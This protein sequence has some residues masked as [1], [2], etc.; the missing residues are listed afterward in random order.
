MIGKEKEEPYGNL[1]IAYQSL[2]DYRKAIQ[3]HEKHLKIALELGDRA[4]EGIA[5]E[6]LGLAYKSLR[7]NQKAIEY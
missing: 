2:D 4:G 1:G 6:N 7:D 3:C 5:Y